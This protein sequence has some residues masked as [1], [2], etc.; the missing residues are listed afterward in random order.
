VG[1]H[2]QVTADQALELSR[3]LAAAAANAMTEV[4]ASIDE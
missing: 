4:G 1:V 3:A 2:F